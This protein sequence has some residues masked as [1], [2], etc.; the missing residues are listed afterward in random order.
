MNKQQKLKLKDSIRAKPSAEDFVII[1][2][3]G[4]EKLDFELASSIRSRKN[5]YKRN[6]YKCKYCSFYHLGG[7]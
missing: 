1:S 4:K 5:N 2:C 3:E 6:I 7:K